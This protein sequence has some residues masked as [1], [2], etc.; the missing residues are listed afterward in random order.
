M[1]RYVDPTEQLVTEIMVRDI[2][3]STVFYR[4]LGFALLRDG[5]S[6]VELTWEE[7]QLLLDKR[8]VLQANHRH[9]KAPESGGWEGNAMSLPAPVSLRRPGHPPQSAWHCTRICGAEPACCAPAAGHCGVLGIEMQL[10]RYPGVWYV[11]S[12]K[13]P[14]PPTVQRRLLWR[15]DTSV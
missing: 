14:L 6:F 10:T 11:L 7:H 15:H 1:N 8:K 13:T 12:S 9:D 2:K 4:R 3:H 5:G